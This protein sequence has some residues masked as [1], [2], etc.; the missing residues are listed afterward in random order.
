MDIKMEEDLEEVVEDCPLLSGDLMDHLGMVN[1]PDLFE[2][3][4]N[5]AF[6]MVAWQMEVHTT[7]STTLVEEEEVM[8]DS[9]VLEYT[10]IASENQQD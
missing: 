5:P 8:Q 2:K 6:Q 4:F 1:N 3:Y 9:R 10:V 7:A